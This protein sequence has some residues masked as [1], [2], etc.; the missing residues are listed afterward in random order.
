MTADD[1]AIPPAAIAGYF[2]CGC[3]ESGIR[4][5]YKPEAVALI[6]AAE[7]RR[8]TFLMADPRDARVLRARADELN[9]LA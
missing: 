6:A 5:G 7:L 4:S 1:L 8:L 3:S 9:G 2:T